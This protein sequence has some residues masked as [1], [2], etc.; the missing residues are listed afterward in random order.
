M[1]TTIILALVLAL[2]GCSAA[3]QPD[4][5]RL[6]GDAG[7]ALDVGPEADADPRTDAASPPRTDAHVP[8]RDAATPPVA[9]AHVEI[10]DGGWCTY[11]PR[12][13]VEYTYADACIAVEV[14]I[15]LACRP[16]ACPFERIERS[17]VELP[18]SGIRVHG[19]QEL[20]ILERARSDCRVIARILA[21]CGMCQDRDPV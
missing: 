8:P 4:A 21:D 12:T 10:R 19:C 15:P 3:I 20:L 16:T 14:H 6:Y 18:I 5:D 9:D 2:V 11:I 17:G 7:E 1:K 13:S